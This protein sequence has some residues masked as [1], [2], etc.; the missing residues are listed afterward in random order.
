M[1]HKNLFDI[2]TKKLWINT[3]RPQHKSHSTG[4]QRPY[5]Y[6]AWLH[7]TILAEYLHKTFP[8]D[9]THFSLFTR[10]ARVVSTG[11][12]M[13]VMTGGWMMMTCHVTWCHES[14]NVMWHDD[15][16]SWEAR[17]STPGSG[18]E[19]LPNQFGKSG[20]GG[21]W[22]DSWGLLPSMISEANVIC[23]YEMRDT[24]L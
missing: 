16:M 7:E 5:K 19:W 20:G 4:A 10:I 24:E 14:D 8:V 21:E 13:I 18:N 3:P 11:H 1:V 6:Q 23:G 2:Q 12:V 15:M 22:I 17:C 9:T